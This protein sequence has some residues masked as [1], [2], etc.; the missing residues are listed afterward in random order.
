MKIL[1]IIFDL[2]PGGAERFV[3]DLS[4]ELSKTNE[5]I[6]LTL[7]NDKVDTNHRQFY[8]YD[9]SPRVKYEN[10]GL[11]DGFNINIL[12]T[13]YKKIK[14]ISPDIVHLN[15]ASVVKYCSLA[16]IMLS[17]KS[18]FFQTIHSDINN[19]Y[20]TTFFKI[21]YGIIGRLKR[22]NL[23]ALSQTNYKDLK[24]KYP[25]IDAI[26]I[27]NGR[28]PIVPTESFS[29]V[30]SEIN[31]L[32]KT[33]TSK[34]F[35]HVARCHPDKNQALL[36]KSFN[37]F[38]KIKNAELCIIGS[39]F[40][41]DAGIKLKNEACEHIHFLGPKKNVCDYM[42]SCDIFC[43]SSSFEGLPITLLE[44]SLAGVPAI[45]TP[46]CGAVDVIS[47]G[48]NG[49]ISKDFTKQEYIKALTNIYEHFDEL[50]ANAVS[51]SKD[52]PYTMEKCAGKY[53]KYFKSIDHVEI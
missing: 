24:K 26:C 23:I 5:V 45:S 38:S 17:R 44:A 32:R 6:L 27:E 49:I 14:S 25:Y 11:P 53:L 4:N 50:K 43:L 35:L 20:S 51:M 48:K 52:S 7:K 8:K 41:T 1:E 13:V 22:I 19:G 3:V 47:S 12:W 18:R 2:S 37:E 21:F 40:D 10:L 34:I 30:Q 29:L 28:A 31:A 9:L 33:D 39:G 46:V 15:L 42:L 36:I 16:T